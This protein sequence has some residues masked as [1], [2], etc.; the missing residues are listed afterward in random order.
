MKTTPENTTSHPL[1]IFPLSNSLALPSMSNEKFWMLNSTN[2][3]KDTQAT[4][5]LLVRVD[6]KTTN[7]TNSRCRF[8][9]GDI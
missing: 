5:E 3:L 6:V 2:S 9:I 4:E 8:F 7:G 1:D